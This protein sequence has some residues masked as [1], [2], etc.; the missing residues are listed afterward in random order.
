MNSGLRDFFAQPRGAVASSLAMAGRR[1]LAAAQNVRVM[2]RARGYAVEPFTEQD[3]VAAG[4]VDADVSQLRFSVPGVGELEAIVVVFSAAD[5]VGKAAMRAVLEATTELQCPRAL[6][7][8]SG[9]MTSGAQKCV[10]DHRPRVTVE[11]FSLAQ[12]AFDLLSHV[13]VPRHR[14]LDDAEKRQ[15]LTRLQC[16][17]GQVPLLK[18]ADPVCKWLALRPG[19]LVEITRT[20]ETE[21]P[22]TVYRIVA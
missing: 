18:Q 1:F 6:V 9:V 11:S 5:R 13:M 3:W 10:E 17:E 21:E 4:G 7:V 20:F 16:T 22:E 15:V 2:L 8:C 12:L 19:T 14:P